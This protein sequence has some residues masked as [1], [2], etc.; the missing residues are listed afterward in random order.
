M[1]ETKLSRTISSVFGRF[2]QT[3]VQKSSS[4]NIQDIVGTTKLPRTCCVD[5]SREQ[6]QLHP[7]N[8]SIVGETVANKMPPHLGEAAAA[9]AAA[10]VLVLIVMAVHAEKCDNREVQQLRLGSV[11]DLIVKSSLTQVWWGPGWDGFETPAVTGSL[12]TL[13]C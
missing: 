8:G 7:E 9:E 5:T 2:W 11:I 12:F 13:P 10:V 3:G 4:E 6:V 1:V